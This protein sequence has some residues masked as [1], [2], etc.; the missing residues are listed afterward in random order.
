VLLIASFNHAVN[1]IK[2]PFPQLSNFFSWF[3]WNEHVFQPTRSSHRQSFLNLRTHFK[4]LEN[5]WHQCT[6][7]VIKRSWSVHKFIWLLNSIIW[8]IVSGQVC[9]I[10]IFCIFNFS[11]LACTFLYKNIFANYMSSSGGVIGLLSGY[12][13]NCLTKLIIYFRVIIK[14]VPKISYIY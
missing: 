3:T 13:N 1:I 11:I 5:I 10:Y 6:L 9:Q 14:I 8:N 12:H 7:K 4:S 2:A